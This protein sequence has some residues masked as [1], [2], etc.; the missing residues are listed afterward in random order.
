MSA[1]IKRCRACCACRVVQFCCC[2]LRAGATLIASLLFVNAC[3]ALAGEA[4]LMFD[5]GSAVA[6]QLEGRYVPPGTKVSL[7][8]DGRVHGG[9]V[10]VGVF[11]LLTSLIGYWAGLRRSLVAATAFTLLQGVNTVIAVLIVLIML[12]ASTTTITTA[13]A[14]ATG[15]CFPCS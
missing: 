10:A 7:Q 4:V 8:G 5:L 14:Q 2:S 6:T 11:E 3:L 12:L 13:L 15:A 1:V 9:L